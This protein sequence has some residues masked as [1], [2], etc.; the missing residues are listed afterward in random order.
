MYTAQPNQVLVIFLGA[1]AAATLLLLAIFITLHCLDRRRRQKFATAANNKAVT[2]GSRASIRM[3]PRP[4]KTL[5]IEIQ[6]DENTQSKEI[7]INPG[8]I[9]IIDNNNIKSVDTEDLG[10]ISEIVKYYN[11]KNIGNESSLSIRRKSLSSG[12]PSMQSLA[13]SENGNI[14]HRDLREF[15]HNSLHMA[16]GHVRRDSGST[17]PR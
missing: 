6:G 8:D 12:T 13:A 7:D 4:P 17:S 14:I 11:S 1:V 10:Y 16:N 9:V 15:H 2:D 3:E 5:T